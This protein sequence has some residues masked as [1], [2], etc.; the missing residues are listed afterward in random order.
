MTVRRSTHVVTTFMSIWFSDM[1]MSRSLI[2]ISI[3]IIYTGCYKNL[4]TKIN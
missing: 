2:D 1:E 4:K 3:P